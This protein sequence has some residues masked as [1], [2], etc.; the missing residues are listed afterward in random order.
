MRIAK[1]PMPKVEYKGKF[2]SLRSRKI[3]LP[4]FSKMSEIEA[5]MW[6]V[7]NTKGRGYSLAGA[8]HVNSGGAIKVN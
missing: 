3:N 4:D 2:Y 1:N 6:L 5:G 8:Q 7:W